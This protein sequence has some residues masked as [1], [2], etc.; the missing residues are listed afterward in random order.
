MRFQLN[1]E[2]SSVNIATL[3]RLCDFCEIFRLVCLTEIGSL[4]PEFCVLGFFS[5]GD[6][7]SF[8][9]GRYVGH[10]EVKDDTHLYL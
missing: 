9:E 4:V 10:F 3:R 1:A 5:N 6:D 2:H 7:W 8:D